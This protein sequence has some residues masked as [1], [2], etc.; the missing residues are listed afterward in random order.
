MLFTYDKISTF[1]SVRLT[2]ESDYARLIMVPRKQLFSASWRLQ[3]ERLQRFITLFNSSM[4]GLPPCVDWAVLAGSRMMT[5][6]KP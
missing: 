2:T 3:L 5:G 4:K 1:Q 6:C